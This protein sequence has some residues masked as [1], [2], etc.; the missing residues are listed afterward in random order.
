MRSFNAK[1]KPDPPASS[2]P[3]SRQ[4]STGAAENAQEPRK[5]I[6]KKLS[7]TI[8]TRAPL[9]D[10]FAAPPPPSRTPLRARDRNVA[11]S[12]TRRP[13]PPMPQLKAAASAR[14]P[15]DRDVH[16]MSSRKPQMPALA[17]PVN[18]APVTPK[19]ASRAAPVAQPQTVTL[20]TPLARRTPRPESAARSDYAPSSAGGGQRDEFVSP[21]AAFLGNNITPRSGSRQSRVDGGATTP[22]GTPILERSDSWETR[23]GLGI[24]ASASED[25]LRQ[26]PTTFS[27]LSDVGRIPQSSSESKFF[28]ASEAKQAQPSGPA[29]PIPPLKKAA[30]FCYASGESIPDNGPASPVPYTPVLGGAVSAPDPLASKFVYANGAPELKQPARG[31]FS[32]SVSGS[33]VSLAAKPPSRPAAASPT[34]YPSPRPA[35]PVKGAPYPITKNGPPLGANR[36][37]MGAAPQL[38]PFSPVIRQQPSLESITSQPRS[39]AHGR[40]ESLTVADPPAVSR[41]LYSHSASGP[42][43][44]VGSP[45]PAA[46]FMSVL[47]AVEDLEKSD[48]GRLQSELN[49][50]TKSTQ[51]QDHLDELVVHARR[52]RKV[53]D[54]EITNA[55]LEAINRS[56]ERQLRKQKNELRQYKRLSRSGRLSLAPS[57]RITSTSTVEG[58]LNDPNQLLSDLSEEESEP[59]DEMEESDYSESESASGESQL[60]PSLVVKRDARHRKQDEKRLQLDLSQH[61][62]MLVDSQKMN[63]SLKRCLSWT[64]EL[65]KEGK[66]ALEFQVRVSEVE[67]GGRVLAPLDEEDEAELGHVGEGQSEED[68]IRPPPED[69]DDDSLQWDKGPDDR[70][71]GV[72]LPAAAAPAST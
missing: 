60:S 69:D 24:S 61:R 58:P 4:S 33:T 13:L 23:S 71:S 50:P 46:G 19:I 6:R 51:P 55:S 12:T 65:I 70:D 31:T 66:K 5:T 17:R 52:E 42:S 16:A 20:A 67:I 26:T 15:P 21:V 56:L 36:V 54:L 9:V 29:R 53:Q 62:Q 72:E 18:R 7:A 63:Q 38:A 28:F 59:E 43:S 41:L 49:S 10:R 2:R 37:A 8:L 68:A 30:T 14:M 40:H 25:R 47:D 45:N 35:S 57:L 1:A 48:T 34:G 64:E 44:P 27:P 39:A 11:P 32:P 3:A 22:N